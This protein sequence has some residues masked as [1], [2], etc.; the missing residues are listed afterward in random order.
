[1]HSRIES[2]NESL[3]LSLV[4]R[5]ELHLEQGGKLV[6][7]EDIKSWIKELS[8]RSS[9]PQVRRQL[10]LNLPNSLS[11]NL[12]SDGLFPKQQTNHHVTPRKSQWMTSLFGRVSQ[13]QALSL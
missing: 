11:N 8:I 1:M 5:D 7:L 2:L 4:E 13:R 3:M 12:F 10:F 6:A 9:I